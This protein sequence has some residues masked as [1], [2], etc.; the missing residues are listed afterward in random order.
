M[1]IMELTER[2]AQ[3]YSNKSVSMQEVERI[4]DRL[5]ILKKGRMVSEGR[6]EE[7][8][9]RYG[10]KDLEEVFIDIVRGEESG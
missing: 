10:R 8:I 1:N 9:F 4:C 3:G 6:P 5:I 2:Q 7:L